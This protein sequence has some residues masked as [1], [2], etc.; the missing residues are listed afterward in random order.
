MITQT[1]EPYT[2]PI[3]EEQDVRFEGVLAATPGPYSGF[4]E[5]ET[6]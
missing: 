4:G 3:C 6:L 5:E 1:K 2:S